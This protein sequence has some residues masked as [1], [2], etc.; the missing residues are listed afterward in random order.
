MSTAIAPTPTTVEV[1]R[2]RGRLLTWLGLFALLAAVVGFGLT[3]LGGESEPAVG[4]VAVPGGSLRLDAVTSEEATH[5]PMAMPGMTHE[6]IG[7]GNYLLRVD[8]TLGASDGSIQYEPDDFTVRG[9]GLD[10]VTPYRAVAGPG[11]VFEGMTAPLL[12]VYEVP[13]DVTS[14][15]LDYAGTRL[16]LDAVTSVVSNSHDHDDDH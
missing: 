14:L 15:T 6:E 16:A 7:E 12:L 13:L 2:R 5:L 9:T 4:V 10:A 11:T 8:A 3:Q 1:S